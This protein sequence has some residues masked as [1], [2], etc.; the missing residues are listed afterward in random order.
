MVDYPC[1]VC[2]GILSEPLGTKDS[3]EF[4]RCRDCGTASV[5]PLP[6]IASV[7]TGVYHSF[8][9]T[10][11]YLTK[12]AKKLRKARNRLARI[13]SD[14]TGKT[15]LDIGCNVGFAVAAALES[16]MRAFGIDVDPVA[17]DI[18][19]ATFNNEA[20]ES[21]SIENYA[22]RGGQVDILY[23]SEVIEHVP[24]PQCFAAAMAKLMKPGGKLFLTTPASDHWRLPSRFTDWDEVKPPMHLVLYSQKGL[25][26]L[27]ERHGFGD[28]R[29]EWKLKPRITL[30][31]RYLA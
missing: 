26:Q 9:T 4:F 11:F 27:L 3:F 16:G 10:P 7:I 1:P 14:P 15:F 28:F 29:F 6:D 17:V 2:S 8:V 24:N 19:R 23:I 25:R 20:F 22:A 18:A 31:A 30:H 12:R 5:V 21:C 13:E